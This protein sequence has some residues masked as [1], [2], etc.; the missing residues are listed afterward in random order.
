MINFRYHVVSL[1]AVLVALGVGLVMGA[2]L[3]S[4]GTGSA[5]ATEV[6]DLQAQAALLREQVADAEATL[7][8]SEQYGQAVQPDQVDGAL[9]DR[10]VV[11]VALPGADE[12]VVS[13]TREVVAQSGARVV[14]TVTVQPEWT[15]AASSA[16]LDALAA[17][18][19]ATGVS[20]DEG[21]DGYQRG[22]VVLASALLEPD[23]G[24]EAEPDVIDTVPAAFADAGMVTVDEALRGTADLA[25]IVAGDPVAD[26]GE[27][28]R[29]LGALTSL[30]V[31]LDGAGSGAV[32]AG[33]PQ[34]ASVLGA[35]GAVR[36]DVDAAAQ[37]STVDMAQTS[38]GRTVA[39]LALAEQQSG[40]V[41]HYGGVG[42]VDGAV[43][44]R[45]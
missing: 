14:G 45:T 26:D 42:E 15:D 16:V 24:T 34:S 6:V 40:G 17:Q 5:A 22:A 29:R 44:P 9:S 10:D 2:G 7:A 12:A 35:V 4:S 23:D 13:A 3:L 25:V 28:G 1:A 33:P 39:V 11:V 41:G 31:A 21:A 38:S 36:D 43:P 37:V 30:A 18:L 8:F 20:L 27:A 32:V 19:V